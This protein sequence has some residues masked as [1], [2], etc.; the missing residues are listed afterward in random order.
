MLKATAQL[1]MEVAA[2]NLGDQKM[3]IPVVQGINGL[4]TNDL[5]S[6]VD[7]MARAVSEPVQWQQCMQTLVDSGVSVVL[8]LGPGGSL[9]KMI[10][11]IYPAISARSVFDFRTPQGLQSWVFREL[12]A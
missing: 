8:E 9:S 11:G 6:G 10:S 5:T 12:E 4:I 3:S 7:S 1:R 2:L